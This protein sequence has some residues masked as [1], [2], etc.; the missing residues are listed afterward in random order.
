MRTIAHIS[1]LH[2]GRHDG[3]V[4]QALIADVSRMR[5]SLI[6]ASG[7]FTQRGRRW[8][9]REAADLLRQ[10]P[11]PQLCVPGNHD[12]PLFDVFRRVFF[13]LDRYRKYICADLRP[14]FRDD[15]I[16]VVGINTAR[17]FSFTFDGFWKDGRVSAEQLLEVKNRMCDAPA[18][19]FK[20]VATHHPFIPPPWQRLKGIVL[21]AARALHQFEQY[22]VDMVLAGHLHVAYS[23]DVRSHHEAVR[24]SLLSIQAGTAVATRRR[25][26]PNAYNLITIDGP[27]VIVDVRAYWEGQ[28]HT[29]ATKRFERRE[30]VWQEIV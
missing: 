29:L 23:G 27:S 13:P 28:F 19:V 10:L 5:P 12:I 7:D 20:V 3:T 2:I 6:I 11:S 26:E 4:V 18:G 17:R 14:V 24:R 16:L 22:G 8:Q 15:E 9:Y 1:D 30:H 21:G 25:G